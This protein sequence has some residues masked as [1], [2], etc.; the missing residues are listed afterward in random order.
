MRTRE[1]FIVEYARSHRNI[2]NQ[3]IHLVCVPLIFFA[4]AGLLW[5]VKLDAVVP[6]LAARFSELTGVSLNLGLLAF[7]PVLAF[8]ARLGLK[9]FIDGGLWSV[10][11]LA[12]IVAIESS[13]A[14]L[15]VLCGVVWVSAWVFQFVGHHIEK[16]KP[17]FGDDLVFLLIGPLFVQEKLVKMVSQ[18]SFAVLRG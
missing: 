2:S 6:Q 15:P 1:Q 14:S 12:A 17:S 8:Y 4:S 9:S 18:R 5:A 11:S 7:V 16:A 3:I 13:G 10:A